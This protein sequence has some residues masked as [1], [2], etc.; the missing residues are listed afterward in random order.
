MSV[1]EEVGDGEVLQAEPVVGL[2][3]LVGDL[4]QEASTHVGDAGVLSG[5]PPYR[6]PMVGGTGLGAGCGTGSSPQANHALLERLGRCE[7]T[8]FG[9]GGCGRHREDGKASVHPNET[10]VVLRRAGR[11]TALR[12][13]VRRFDSR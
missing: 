7:A 9:A 6:L 3:E 11:A 5:Q 13:E 12:M 10:I 1:S 8:G 2:D 4:V